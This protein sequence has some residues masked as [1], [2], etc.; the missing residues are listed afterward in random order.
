MEKEKR[1]L[2]HELEEANKQ[3]DDILQEKAQLSKNNAKMKDSVKESKAALVDMESKLMA[4]INENCELKRSLELAE[5]KGLNKIKT[6][7]SS[8]TSSTPSY[9][10]IKVSQV[11]NS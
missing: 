3:I 10:F 8:K 2:K 7:Q 5:K 1:Y 4:A 6:S 9:D 11:N